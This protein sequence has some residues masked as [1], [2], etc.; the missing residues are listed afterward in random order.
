VRGAHWLHLVGKGGKPG[1]VVLP[2]LARTALDRYLVQRCLPAAQ[3][4]WE[5]KAHL[6]GGLA[7]DIATPS[8]R[9]DCG[10]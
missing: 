4:R 3:G 5:P 1:K 8:P 9:R 2:P 7:P 10:V 6:I